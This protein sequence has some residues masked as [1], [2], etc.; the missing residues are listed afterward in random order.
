[1]ARSQLESA[2]LTSALVENDLTPIFRF[3]KIRFHNTLSPPDYRSNH[4]K[5]AKSGEGFRRSS[6]F[7]VPPQSRL[8]SAKDCFPDADDFSIHTLALGADGKQL[9]VGSANTSV[10]VIGVPDGGQLREIRPSKWRLG[11]PIT[12]LRYIP[13]NINWVLGS[14]PEGEIFCVS[15]NQEGFETLIKEENR[16]TYCLDISSDGTEM[17]TAG[18]DSSIRIYDIHPTQLR[19]SETCSVKGKS[20]TALPTILY[21]GDRY[22]KPVGCSVAKVAKGRQ[23]PSLNSRMPQILGYRPAGPADNYTDGHSMRITALKYHPAH[24][25]IL[26]SASWDHYVKIWDTRTRNKPI[27]EIY[28][29]LVC[30][31]DGLDVDG[32]YVLT[33]SWRKSQAL[34]V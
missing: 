27:Y 7:E 11:M 30:S 31:P 10:K 8:W 20:S 33:A 3:T 16:Q 13:N 2:I 29:P 6:S 15:P 34:E 26:L 21:F 1:M 25:S 22:E 24:P 17:A 12:C 4:I 32:H 9:I 23:N 5:E 19:G 18:N 28:G 14:T